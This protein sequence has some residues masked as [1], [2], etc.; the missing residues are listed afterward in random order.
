[1]KP[2][3]QFQI[4][5]FENPNK[6]LSWRVTGTRLNGERVR[7]N[8]KTEAEALG[9]KQD[10]EIEASNFE[11]D[12][13]LATTRLTREQVADAENFY[14]ELERA[15]MA[16]KGPSFVLRFFLDNYRETSKEITLEDAMV[17]F[18]AERTRANDRPLTI[19]NLKQR[20]GNVSDNQPK[21]LVSAVLEAEIKDIVFKQGRGPVAQDNDRRALLQ[22]FNWATEKKY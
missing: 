11:P 10:L 14:A 21:K 6:T 8:F 16:D 5:E 9:R 20:V 12:H 13:R 7:E 1:M 22:F 19:R 15:G 4:T 17:E 3:G 2:R 18:V